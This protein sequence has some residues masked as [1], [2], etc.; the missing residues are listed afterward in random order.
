MS[1]DPFESE[2]C[3]EE[4]GITDLAAR[5]T[6][7]RPQSAEQR[8]R[9]ELQLERK[10]HEQIVDYAAPELA[11]LR[12][13]LEAERKAHEQIADYLL[14]LVG[15]GDGTSVDAAKKAAEELS[16]L[17][18]ERDEFK[19]VAYRLENTIRLLRTELGEWEEELRK[20]E[21]Q[22][23]YWQ[24]RAET[25]ELKVLT[26]HDEIAKLPAPSKEE[27]H[28]VTCDSKFSE[29]INGCPHCWEAGIRSKVVLKGEHP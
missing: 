11:R 26:F 15:T 8:L 1:D 21:A 19:E 3:D 5:E 7:A 14:P 25:A 16:R 20:A 12:T 9:A 2:S 10:A 18:A 4:L 23:D 28:C 17:R 6:P 27:W 13:E 29:Y 22:R 24:A